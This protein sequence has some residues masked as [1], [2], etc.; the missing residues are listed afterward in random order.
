M[1]FGSFAD[2]SQR[3][4]QQ[5]DPCAWSAAILHFCS[6]NLLFFVIF[7]LCWLSLNDFTFGGPVDAVSRDVEFILSEGLYLNVDKC[8]VIC[9]HSPLLDLPDCLSNFANIDLVNATLFGCST[10]CR[11]SFGRCLVQSV[12]YV[13]KGLSQIKSG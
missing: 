13:V 12:C 11:Q 4:N 2:V 3:V 8:E 7:A 5:G 6:Q 1:R 9:Y 10:F